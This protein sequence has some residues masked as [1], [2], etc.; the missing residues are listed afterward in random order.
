MTVLDRAALATLP[1][2]PRWLM[3]RLAARY[4]AGEQLTDALRKLEDLRARGFSGILDVLGEDVQDEAAARTA[5]AG[6]RDAASALVE[7]GLD[8]Y[9]SVKPTHFGLRL[10]EELCF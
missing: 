9:V 4:I 10:S 5:A 1:F 8:A 6:Y 3:R 2:L 7:R